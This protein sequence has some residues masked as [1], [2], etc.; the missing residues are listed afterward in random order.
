MSKIYIS[1]KIT[2]DDNFK[3]KFEKAATNCH[4]SGWERNKILNPCELPVQENWHDYMI[5]DIKELFKCSHIFMLQDWK[6]S[7]GARIEH[8]IAKETGLTII[9]QQ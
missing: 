8:A 2:G 6:E 5:M 1:G 4:L 3:R 9:Y 7:K